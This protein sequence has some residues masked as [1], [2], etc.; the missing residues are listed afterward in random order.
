MSRFLHQF[1]PTHYSEV[2]SSFSL[3]A[4]QTS[5][6]CSNEST[7][8][9]KSMHVEKFSLQVPYLFMKLSKF[10]V[11]TVW[12]LSNVGIDAALQIR[13]FAIKWKSC[14]TIRTY[15]W[16]GDVVSHPLIDASSIQTCK[17]YIIGWI[18]WNY[19][20]RQPTSVRLDIFTMGKAFGMHK[21]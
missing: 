17:Y 19:I 7:R 1:S 11:Q 6:L 15:L 13:L 14:E 4:H 10:S 16:F 20:T 3:L 9:R 2:F 8:E 18:K 12:T 5:K 21:H